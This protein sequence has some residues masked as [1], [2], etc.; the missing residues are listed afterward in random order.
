MIGWSN[1]Y[2]G[3]NNADFSTTSDQRIKKN[4]VNNNTGLSIINNIQVK[5][6][7]YKTKE[8][9]K[10]A[11]PSFTDAQVESAVVEKSGTQ[12]GLIAQELETVLPNCVAEN[13]WGVKSVERDELFW[14]M[15]NAIKELSAKVTALE[16]G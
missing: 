15:L 11:F 9:V 1:V 6:F 8:E 10:E 12:L 3:G 4:I 16:G 7:E 14:Y 5:N 13:D 2:H